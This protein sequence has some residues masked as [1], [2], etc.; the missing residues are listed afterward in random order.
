MTETMTGAALRALLANDQN[1]WSRRPQRDDPSTNGF[2]KRYLPA[3]RDDYATGHTVT[4][5]GFDG[6]YGLLNDA[7]GIIL[8]GPPG[9][10]KTHLAAAF[11]NHAFDHNRTD[12]PGWANT[13]ELFDTMRN[14]YSNPKIEVPNYRSCDWMV[15]EDIGRERPSPFVVEQF[16]VLINRAYEAMIPVIVTTNLH[17]DDL[18]SFVGEQAFDRVVEMCPHRINLNGP[19]RRRRA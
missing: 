4:T 13:A 12:R 1:D 15:F 5:E 16:Y 3:S 19:S 6:L 17:P 18:A 10:G 14:S 11:T 2:P 9:T 8:Y 7:Q